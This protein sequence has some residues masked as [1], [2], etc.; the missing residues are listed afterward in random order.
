MVGKMGQNRTGEEMIILIQIV[1][2]LVVPSLIL[3]ECGSFYY[4]A[5][6]QVLIFYTRSDVTHFS[7]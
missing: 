4:H 6:D 7:G 3:P 1:S 5:S 2:K